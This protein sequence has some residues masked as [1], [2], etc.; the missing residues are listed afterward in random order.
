M[1]QIS[2]RDNFRQVAAQV[3]ALRKDQVPYACA[4]ALTRTAKT[5]KE[6]EVREMGRVFDRPTPYTLNALYV[7]P[8]TKQ[9]LTSRVWLKDDTSKGTPA[10]KYLLP[11]IEGGSRVTKRFERALAAIG[12]MPPGY[13][14]V[15]GLGAKLDSYGNW[16]RGQ[17][18]QVLAW[19][20]A[21]RDTASNTTAE[22]RQR[23]T[24][25]RLGRSYG[26]AFFAIY[27][28]RDSHLHPGIYERIRT[29]FGSA[30]RPI[31]VFVARSQY[32]PRFKFYDVAHRVV[33]D[34]FRTEFEIAV[35]QAMATA[36]PLT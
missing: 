22:K 6:E 5:V 17:L 36:R 26:R 1:L 14:I 35:A 24:A 21:M 3:Q 12:V 7:K 23:K 4:V 20:G 16:N 28:G 29:G 34:R 30:I 27:P 25:G 13:F 10:S 11:E 15:P 2:V 8:A 33:A 32:G 9:D 19:F 18:V 31:A